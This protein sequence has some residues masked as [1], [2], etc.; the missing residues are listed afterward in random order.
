MEEALNFQV[1]PQINNSILAESLP[2]YIDRPRTDIQV[3]ILCVTEGGVLTHQLSSI[4]DE[5]NSVFQSELF[6]ILSA[7]QYI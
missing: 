4:L 5:N 7:L 3:A 2:I 1:N 6:A